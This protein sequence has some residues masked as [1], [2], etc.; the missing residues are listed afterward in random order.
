ME[1]VILK[2]GAV[3]VKSAVMIIMCAIRSLV[4]KEPMGFY[5][6]IEICRNPQHKPWGDIGKTLKEANLITEHNDQWLVHETIRNTALSA[7]EGEGLN[8]IFSNPIKE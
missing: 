7:V 4:S 5:E 1:T 2:N 8:I 6:L 3:E